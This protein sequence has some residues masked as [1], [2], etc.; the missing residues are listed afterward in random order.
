ML[1]NFLSN[2]IM[3]RR[4]D[5]F[6]RNRRGFWSLWI[7]LVL[8]TVSLFAEFVANDKPFIVVYD[9]Q[10]YAPIFKAYPE[11]TFGGDFETEAEYSDPEVAELIEEKGW[12]VWPLIPYRFDTV[13]LGLPVPSPSPPTPLS[14]RPNDP[15]PDGSP[16][17]P[18]HRT[19]DETSDHSIGKVRIVSQTQSVIKEKVN[20]QG[21]VEESDEFSS[22]V[23]LY[24]EN[25]HILE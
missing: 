23:I 20:K 4:L 12:I 22:T 2:P 9:G 17:R 18:R 3:R 14:A 25:Q 10:I 15:G 6:V 5:T 8:F 24:F 11:T 7:F 19:N 13:V 1:P 21:I 16:P